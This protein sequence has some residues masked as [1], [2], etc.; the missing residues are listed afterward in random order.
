MKIINNLINIRNFN[1]L[2]QKII[3]FKFVFI[4]A[5]IFAIYQIYYSPDD[6]Q[7]ANA[8]K[9]MYIHVPAAW[10]ALALY[11]FMAISSLACLIWQNNLSFYLAVA[12]SKIGAVFAFITLV[13]GAIW[14]KPMWGAWWV[15]DARLTSMLILFFFYIGY[16]GLVTSTNNIILLQKPASILAIIGFINVPLVKFS[17]NLWHSLHQPASIL[18]SEGVAIDK[19]MLIPLFSMFIAVIILVIIM[20]VIE[21]K[22]LILQQK[23]INRNIR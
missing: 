13:T 6:Y 14:G 11:S 16:I 5:M 3:Y 20:L 21:T 19:T 22:S 10:L 7:Q 15:W 4:V 18:R 17:V 8:V 1:F 9:I 23:K 2:Y 12:S